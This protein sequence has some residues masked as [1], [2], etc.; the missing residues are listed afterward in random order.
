MSVHQIIFALCRR[1]I[2]GRGNGMQVYSRDAAFQDADGEELRQLS[3][4]RSPDMDGPMTDALAKTMPQA[5]KYRR[6]GSGA[7]ALARNTYQGREYLSP[8]GRFGCH[9]SHVIVC[10]LEDMTAYPAEY[11]GGALLRDSMT[12]EEVN[13]LTPPPCLPAP[14]LERSFVVTIAAA[15]A[16]LAAEGRM[17]VYRRM[18]QAALSFRRTG[19]RVILLDTPENTLF[20][21]A[22]LGYALPRRCARELSFSTYEYDPARAPFRVCGAVR[23]GTRLEGGDGHFLFDPAKGVLPVR[24]PDPDPAFSAFL[25]EAFTF[26]FDRLRD[27]HSFL[28]EGY[29]YDQADEDLYGAFALYALLAGGRDSIPAK[30]AALARDFAGRYAREEEFSRVVRL[31]PPEAEDGETAGEGPGQ[32]PHR[33][34]PEAGA[35]DGG[36]GLEIPPEADGAPGARRPLFQ[37]LKGMFRRRG[38]GQKHSS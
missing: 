19:K 26:P 28:E 25:S 32:T 23:E 7:L 10:G 5:W 35:P 31:L 16:F 27:F 18:L 37:D 21:I 38:N 11:L 6:L 22:A 34:D 14:L 12:F 36:A 30:R 2:D 24:E 13:R 15:S 9:M 20:W 4:Y 1:G 33:R 29:T 3:F 17:E 8:E